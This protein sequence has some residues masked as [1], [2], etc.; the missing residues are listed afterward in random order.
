[1]AGAA[2]GSGIA[3]L[4]QAMANQGQMQTQ[5]ISASIGQQEA[6]NQRLRAQ[7]AQQAQAMEQRAEFQIGAGNQFL[8]QQEADRA[9]TLVGVQMGSAAGA[10]QGYQNALLNQ[11][12]VDAAASQAMMG[13]LTSLAS[14]AITADYSS[15][16]KTTD[17]NQT[18]DLSRSTLSGTGVNNINPLYQSPAD[19]QGGMGAFRIDQFGNTQFNNLSGMSIYDQYDE[20]GNKINK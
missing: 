19:S 20:F 17:P 18:Y 1:M 9:A 8:Q 3:S 5:Q 7:G 4:A 2:G 6:M 13:S 12:Q 11:Q 16:S 14:T 10:S 15:L